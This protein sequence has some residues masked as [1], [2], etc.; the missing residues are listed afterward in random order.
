MRVS[1]SYEIIQKQPWFAANGNDSVIRVTVTDAQPVYKSVYTRRGGC[2]Q[3]FH[4][5]NLTPSVPRDMQSMTF[6]RGLAV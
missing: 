1:L 2:I 5:I 6:I 4:T 3:L